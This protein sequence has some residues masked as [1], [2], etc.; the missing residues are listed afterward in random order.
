MYWDVMLFVGVFLIVSSIGLGSVVALARSRRTLRDRI[1]RAMIG[2]AVLAKAAN[3]PTPPKDSLGHRKRRA[4]RETT[5]FGTL[6]KALGE[7]GLRLSPSELIIGG[8][9]SGVAIFIGAVLGLG[10]SSILGLVLAIGVPVLSVRVL[11]GVAQAK[12]IAQFTHDL[13][14]ALDVFG[15]GLRA[16]RPVTDSIGLTA[17]NAEPPLK[18]EFALCRDQL[19]L[20]TDMATAFRNL[21]E[22]M[23]TPE[24]KFFAVAT[25]LQSETGGNLIETIE[26]LTEQLRERRKLR[27]KIKA[28]SA[29][30]RVSATILAG[31]PFVIGAVI[32]FVS[33]NY[34]SPL[35]S[36]QRG[37]LML[38]LAVVS[39]VLG[40]YVMTRMGKIDV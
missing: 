7:A 8:T 16:G 3:S 5:V 38:G 14:E 27:K 13:P 28:L 9:L 35:F 37:Q 21:S 6:E 18:G 30:V 32:L 33:P 11:V 36:D 1:D 26:G 2:T 22:R 34:L 24:V 29:E 31:L 25:A 20:G 17:A 40:V 19:R 12:R 10:L 15:R 4:G 23:P 39:V